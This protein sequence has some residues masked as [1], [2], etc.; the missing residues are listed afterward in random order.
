MTEAFDNSVPWTVEDY[1]VEGYSWVV[2]GP[3]RALGAMPT[4]YAYA[5]VKAHNTDMKIALLEGA[6]EVGDW[7]Q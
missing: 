2:T 6:V 7:T 3:D 5:I 4:V 1:P